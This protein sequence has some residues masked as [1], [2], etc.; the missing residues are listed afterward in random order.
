[1]RFFPDE[2]DPQSI[3]STLL[4]PLAAHSYAAM[5]RKS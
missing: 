2:E 5:G 4:D 1:V 3:V